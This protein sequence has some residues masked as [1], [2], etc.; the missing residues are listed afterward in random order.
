MRKA[1]G[2]LLVLFCFV[3]ISHSQIYNFRYLNNQ[4]GLPQSQAFSVEFDNYGRAWV[5]TQGG[6]VAIFD[7]VNFEYLLLQDSLIS[8]RIYKLKNIQGEIYVGGKGGISI[9]NSD[10]EW[11]LNKYFENKTLIVQDIIKYKDEIIIGTTKG[12]F[13]LKNE[14]LQKVDFF[15]DLIINSFFISNKNDLWINTTDGM[16]QFK[17]PLNRINKNRGLKNE[18]VTKVVEF[19][20]NWFI[21]TYGSGIYKYDSNK[22]IHSKVLLELKNKIVLDLKITSNKLWIAT[23]NSGVYTYDILEDNLIHYHINNGLSNN[24][25]KCIDIDYWGNVWLGTSGGGVSIYNDSPFLEYNKSN[26]LNSNYIFSVLPSTS[27]GLWIGTQGLGVVKITDS[28][29]ALI[30]EDFG[31]KTVKTKVLFE[32]SKNGIWFGTE[33]EGLWLVHELNNKD[34]ALNFGNLHGL[35][36]KWIKSID[37]NIKL[38]DLYVGTTNGIFKGKLTF[39][40]NIK[41]KKLKSANLP[42][43]INQLK[44]STN[45]NSLFFAS[46]NGAGYIIGNRTFLIDN[47]ASFRNV[48]INDSMA[49]FGTVDK[50]VLIAKK[51]INGEFHTIGWINNKNGLKSNNVYQ[52]LING[53]YLWVGTEKGLDEYD[54]INETVSHFGYEEGLEGV[55]TNINSNYLDQYGNLWFGTTN[56]LFK[57]LNQP[58][59]ENKI[60]QKPI[61]F[62]SD[63]QV[64]YEPISE[65]VYGSMYKNDSLIRLSYKDNHVGFLLKSIHLSQSHKIKYRWKLDKVMKE[66]SPPSEINMATFSNLE[67]GTYTFYAKSAIDNNW[68]MEAVN[69]NFIIEPPIWQRLWF[70]ITYI[71]LSIIVVSLLLFA[72]YRRNIKKNKAILESIKLE[73]SILELEQK[74]LRLQMNPHFIFNVL[75]SIH[76]LII[77]ND[78]GKARYALS[79]FSK[80]MRQVLENS[81]EKLISIDDELETIKNYIQ[82]E[83]LTST[84]T[85][86]LEIEIDEKL[87]SNEQLLPPLLIQPFVENAIIHGFKGVDYNG[88]IKLSFKLINEHLL[89]CKIIDNGVGRVKSRQNKSQQETIH[90]S[91]ALEVTQER[92]ANLNVDKSYQSFEI[93]NLKSDGTGTVITIKLEI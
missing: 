21:A 55:E 57:Y 13:I 9:F 41:F 77:L 63:I 87:D 90:K 91:T 38:N 20:N 34:T 53:Q 66:W 3:Q 49:W 14:Q 61:F 47:S 39:D 8:N 1:I 76:N 73:K 48:V 43:R 10:G 78:S 2:I 52:L 28:T 23:Q 40:N 35:H 74:A 15:K 37:E 83:K 92:L 89:E 44:W 54:F 85:F 75:N 19:N 67:P 46:P 93:T 33:G 30:D 68:D 70:K 51:D 64:F 16:Y 36:S 32:D 25:V 72:I 11:I 4:N 82:L 22:I 58:K 56:G 5:A 42:K 81:R 59:K 69:F 71:S 50:G 6:G 60:T 12:I 17:N 88:V 27:K 45:N 84:S 18:F 7:G 31:F 80:L 65:T 24:H 86:D 29:S 26:G 79:K 62:I